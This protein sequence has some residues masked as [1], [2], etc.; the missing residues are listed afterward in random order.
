MTSGSSLS[1]GFSGAFSA[2]EGA[3]VFS[4]AGETGATLAVFVTTGAALFAETGLIALIIA[5]ALPPCMMHKT[6]Q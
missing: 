6:F 4:A 2:G 1:F 5:M 3:D